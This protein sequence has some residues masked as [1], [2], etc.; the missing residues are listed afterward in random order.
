M[1]LPDLKN[2]ITVAELA[3]RYPTILS[4]GGIR[5]WLRQRN[6]NNLQESGAIIKIS[7]KLYID[8]PKFID[9]LYKYKIKE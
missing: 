4:V 9:W 6:E 2:L 3:K 1:T 7:R 8:E 5:V